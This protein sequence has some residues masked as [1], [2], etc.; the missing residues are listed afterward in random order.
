MAHACPIA[1]SLYDWNDW[2]FSTRFRFFSKPI[3]LVVT[4]GI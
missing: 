4:Y 3:K 1:Y 2:R